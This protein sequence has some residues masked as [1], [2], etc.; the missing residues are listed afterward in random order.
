MERL[1]TVRRLTA[2][3]EAPALFK[4]MI[5][6][7]GCAYLFFGTFKAMHLGAFLIIPLMKGEADNREQRRRLKLRREFKEAL[8][9]MK[10]ALRAGYSMENTVGETRRDMEKVFGSESDIV[11]EF[12]HME[13][14]IG[15][16]LPVE[17]VFDSFAARARIEDITDFAAVLRTAKRSGGDLISITDSTAAIIG[18]KIELEAEIQTALAAR[19]L[20]WKIMSAIPFLIIIYMRVCFP[21]FMSVLYT[22]IT[23]RIVMTTAIGILGGAFLLGRRILSI[24]V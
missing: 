18:D 6:L 17:Q 23:G 14:E 11:K 10:T 5:L 13:N 8:I 16:R 15:L 2:D 12:R 20:E 3:W 21:Q 4:N 7:G 1:R 24:E 19:K 22:T 9:S